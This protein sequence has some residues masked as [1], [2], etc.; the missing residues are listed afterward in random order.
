MDSLNSFNLFERDTLRRH[1]RS[2]WSGFQK[3]RRRRRHGLSRFFCQR[4]VLQGSQWHAHAGKIRGV[5]RVERD[6]SLVDGAS[7]VERAS[8]RRGVHT[9]PPCV[10]KYP[11]RISE[12]FISRSRVCYTLSPLI[13]GRNG[14]VH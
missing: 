3:T 4:D 13:T 8:E 11:A 5:C 1:S 14:A 9:A 2:P 6:F 10:L 7:K 12:G